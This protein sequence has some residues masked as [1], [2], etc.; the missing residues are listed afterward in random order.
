MDE[1]LIELKME[2]AAAAAAIVDRRLAD[3]YRPDPQGGWSYIDEYD[4]YVELLKLMR[5]C[6]LR[7]RGW[8]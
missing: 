8:M 1:Q 5:R 7:D 2:A 3:G 6:E 4:P